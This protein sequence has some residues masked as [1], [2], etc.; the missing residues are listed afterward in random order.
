MTN[1]AAITVLGLLTASTATLGYKPFQQEA[2]AP[3][4]SSSLG[5]I[6]E[7]ADVYQ[8]FSLAHADQHSRR[9]VGKRFLRIQRKSQIAFAGMV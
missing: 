7:T 3:K 4:D 6:K 5:R 1:F 2:V 8:R 9:F